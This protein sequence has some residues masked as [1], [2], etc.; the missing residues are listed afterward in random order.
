MLGA[1]KDEFCFLSIYFSIVDARPIVGFVEI[2]F[3]SFTVWFEASDL[4]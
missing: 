3:V 2:W 1:V 4:F